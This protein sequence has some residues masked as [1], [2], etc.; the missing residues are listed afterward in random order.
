MT[1]HEAVHLV[2]QSAVIGSHGQTLILD[3]GSPVKI[4]DLAKQMI[5]RSGKQIEIQYTG[6]RPGEKLHETLYSPNER[7]VETK[8]KSI[9]STRVEGLNLQDPISLF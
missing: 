1:I 5:N 2:L 4:E 9:T 7:V 6:L 8:H 3:M